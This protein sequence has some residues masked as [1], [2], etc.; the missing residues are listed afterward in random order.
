MI[1]PGT[2]KTRNTWKMWWWHHRHV[3]LGVSC[4]W[5]SGVHQKYAVWVLV[6][7]RIK[8]HIE[9]ALPIGI[10]VKTQG[11]MSKIRTKKVVFL[12]QICQVNHYS[13][14]IL[15]KFYSFLNFNSQEFI[16]GS[17]S[18]KA[19]FRP[20]ISS[21]AFQSWRTCFDVRQQIFEASRKIEDMIG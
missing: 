16:V 6:G 11:D 1:D 17:F 3:F 5:G 4:S 14:F 13:W 9:R 8:F 10:W 2:L 18:Y 15:F 21:N 20:Q 12:W 7:C 19:H